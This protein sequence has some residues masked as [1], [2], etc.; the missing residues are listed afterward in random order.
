MKAFLLANITDVFS[1]VFGL[2]VGGIEANPIIQFV[3][4][5]TSIPEALLVKLAIAAG[6]G[7]M[8]NRWKPRLLAIPTVVFTLIAISNS[9]VAIS[10]A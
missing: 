7:L 1:T 5:A 10:Y 6:I 4:E 8:I 2:N 9:L 3:I